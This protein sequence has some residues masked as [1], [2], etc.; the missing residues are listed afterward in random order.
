ME[1]NVVYIA[2]FAALVAALGLTPRIY[3]GFGVPITVQT[4]G[5]MLCG[6]MLGAKRGALAMLL[7]LLVMSAGL[8][9]VAGGLGGLGMFVSVTGGFLVGWPFAAFVTG[10]IVEKWRGPSLAVVATIASMVGGILVMYVFGVIG[11]SIVLEKTLL[12]STLLVLAF[13]PG[14]IV[15]AVV[16]GTLTAAIYKARPASVLSRAN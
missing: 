15:K 16:A 12:E 10:L 1:K 13:V 4:V 9:V 5:V 6:S 11:M 8:P 2:L 7:F 14:D 3:L